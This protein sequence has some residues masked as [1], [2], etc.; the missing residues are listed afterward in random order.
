VHEDLHRLAKIDGVLYSN[1]VKILEY[2]KAVR[3]IRGGEGNKRRWQKI[4]RA[5]QIQEG[6]KRSA[7]TP[8]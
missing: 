3:H 2:H 7:R 8:R 1:V 6:W 4:K 5:R